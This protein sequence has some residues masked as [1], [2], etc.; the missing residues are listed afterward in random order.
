MKLVTF[1]LSGAKQQIGALMDDGYTLDLL[2]Q[3]ETAM[4]GRA[5]S[6]Y[7]DM[8]AFLH[9]GFAARER[10]QNVLEFITR[11]HPMGTTTPLQ[12]VTL[13]ATNPI[14]ASMRD[15]AVFETTHHQLNP[16]SGI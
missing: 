14:P 11:E 9:G 3:G 5:S 10:A 2:A 12:N 13:L 1:A 7:T 4:D 15:C 6:F 8:M 16:R